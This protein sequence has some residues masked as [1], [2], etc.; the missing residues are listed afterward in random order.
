LI[1]WFHE[2]GILIDILILSG[3]RTFV[4]SAIL[5]CQP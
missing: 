3:F 5:Q 2:L 4:F 1:F